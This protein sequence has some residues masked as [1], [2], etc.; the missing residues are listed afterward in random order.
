[1]KTFL[2]TPSQAGRLLVV[3]LVAVL[4]SP[5]LRED[6][7]EIVLVLGVALV[8]LGVVFNGFAS[9][10]AFFGTSKGASRDGGA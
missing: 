5:M 3:G 1:M 10:L 2:P 6:L 4:A 7:S 8:V 9:V